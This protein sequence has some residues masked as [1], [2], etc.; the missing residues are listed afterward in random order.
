MD[1]ES[2]EREAEWAKDEAVHRVIRRRKEKTEN[3]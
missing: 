1:G 3:K 2:E